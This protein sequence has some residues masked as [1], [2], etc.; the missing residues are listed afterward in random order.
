MACLHAPCKDCPFKKDTTKG[1]LGKERTQSLVEGFVKDE[2]HFLCHKTT[3]NKAKNTAVCAG[4][5]NVMEKAN[6]YTRPIQ[7][8]E[9]LG[10][11]QRK[12]LKGKD[13][14][15]DSLTDFINHH[16]FDNEEP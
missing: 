6:L 12:Q 7:I 11:Y 1:W 3:H 14:T 8:L 13:V 10:L 16:D 9:R 2:D 15:F 5:L 4:W